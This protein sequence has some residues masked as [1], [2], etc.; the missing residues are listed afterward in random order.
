[1]QTDLTPRLADRNALIAVVGATDNQWKYG[2]IIYLDL[3]ARGHRVVGVNPHRDT[4]DGDRCYPNL[5]ALPE[6]P[7]LIDMVVPPWEGI[8]VARE[9]AALGYMRI[10][11]QPGS[12]IPKLLEYLEENGFDYLA[13]SCIM[14]RARLVTR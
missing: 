6:A 1:M 4:V 2:S 7:D 13:D 5:A 9:A 12:E 3:K 14:V 8:R 11:L 10:W